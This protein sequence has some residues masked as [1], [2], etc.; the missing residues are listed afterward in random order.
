MSWFVQRA[1]LYLSVSQDLS[2]RT[3]IE[4]PGQVEVWETIESHGPGKLYESEGITRFRRLGTVTSTTSRLITRTT[5]TIVT[6]ADEHGM[7]RIDPELL[8]LPACPFPQNGRVCLANSTGLDTT[9]L[10]EIRKSGILKG[11]GYVN[12]SC[13]Y[14]YQRSCSVSTPGEVVLFYWPRELPTVRN[15]HNQTSHRVAVVPAIT[16]RGPDLYPLSWSAIGGGR[17]FGTEIQH[18]GPETITGP[19][20][21]TSPTIYLAHHPVTFAYTSHIG[22]GDST[23]SAS[24][25]PPGTISLRPQDVSSIIPQ[26]SSY[27]NG[28]QYASLVANGKFKGWDPVEFE[29]TPFDFADLQGTVPASAYFDARW[30]DCW[31]EQ[32]HCRTITDDNHRPRLF[33]SSTVWP[34]VSG[35]GICYY[36]ELVDPPIA[37]TPLPDGTPNEEDPIFPFLENGSGRADRDVAASATATIGDTPGGT[38]LPLEP[39]PI[40]TRHW[41]LPTATCESS[42]WG[43]KG[44]NSG[45]GNSHNDRTGHSENDRHLNSPNYRPGYSPHDSSRKP[46]NAAVVFNS[47]SRSSN[48]E[49]SGEK[50]IISLALFSFSTIIIGL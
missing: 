13:I 42:T 7:F 17:P 14:L 8:A 23:E 25:M 11:D 27:R 21:F 4:Y 12:G 34:S 35:Q 16:F 20:T 24:V 41:P 19:F 31:G 38:A 48:Q 40:P 33:I 46:Y 18:I 15:G 22:F 29:T 1:R 37:L 50:W 49:L 43:P 6:F 9:P 39:G 3:T 5:S 2:Q 44:K 45:P 36:P 28:T 10:E 47:G 32:T 30:H 26:R